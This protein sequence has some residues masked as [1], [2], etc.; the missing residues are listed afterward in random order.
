MTDDGLREHQLAHLA[1]AETP[2]HPTFNFLASHG[3]IESL[4]NTWDSDIKRA[5]RRAAGARGLG[6]DAAQEFAQAARI[7]LA[8][9]A[10]NAD[11]LGTFYVRRVIQNAVRDSVRRDRRM[12]GLAASLDAAAA[13]AVDPATEERSN[14]IDWI[15][16]WV[17]LLP[18][19]L[20]HL[21]NLLYVQGYTQ[22][23][24]APLLGVSQPRVTQ[25]H[26]ELLRRGRAALIERAA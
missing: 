4:I 19:R 10:V 21:Y 23:E 25:L 7:A 24:A 3:D 12:F 18:R 15:A 17:S 22:R 16:D 20:N 14:L 1:G 13:A 8:R 5:A 6:Y 11:E 2:L 26:Q 9:I